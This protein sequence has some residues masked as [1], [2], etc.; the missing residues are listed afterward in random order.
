GVSSDEIDFRDELAGNPNALVEV[1]DVTIDSHVKRVFESTMRAFGTVDAVVNNA[2]LRQRDL[3]PPHGSVT[4]LDTEVGDWQ[5]M[6]D[7]QVFG[8]VRVIKAFSAP[9]LANRRGS[10]INIGSSAWAGQNP[11]TRE[12]PYKSAK[13]AVGTLTFYLAHELRPQNV[14]VNLLLPGHT[15]STGSDEQERERAEIRSKLRP[16]APPSSPLRMRPE[17]VVPLALFLADQDASGVTG[18]EL[19]AVRWNEAQGLGAAEAWAYPP[20]VAARS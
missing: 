8:V 12:M 13:G 20:D 4:L 17:H 1:M 2:G 16:D 7:T 10:I 11:D 3:Y 9:M 18:Q 5:R 15:R 14:A 6:F 19:S